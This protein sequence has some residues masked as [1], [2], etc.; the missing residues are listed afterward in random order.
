MDSVRGQ[1]VQPEALNNPYA[2]THAPPPP[3]LAFEGGQLTPQLSLTSL[4]DSPVPTR[5]QQLLPQLAHLQQAAAA[6]NNKEV[7]GS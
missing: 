5:S 2:E 1:Q 4:T 7:C 3:H 6:A